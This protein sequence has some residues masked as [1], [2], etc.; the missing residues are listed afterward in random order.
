MDQ[1]TT[2]AAVPEAPLSWVV[3]RR[4]HGEGVL[5]PS[6]EQRWRER[7]LDRLVHRLDQIFHDHDQLLAAVRTSAA[8][9]NLFVD[10]TYH[11]RLTDG[12]A[13]LVNV[14][15]SPGWDCTWPRV[16][17]RFDLPRELRHAAGSARVRMSPI[18]TRGRQR[19][20]AVSQPTSTSSTSLT[21]DP[22]RPDTAASCARW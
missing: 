5:G 20:S 6:S 7:G 8:G 15:P 11:W 12:L 13:L 3:P 9:T 2:T 10:V 22:R 18:P 17:V 16:G 1:P 4:P 19:G 14:V 21:P